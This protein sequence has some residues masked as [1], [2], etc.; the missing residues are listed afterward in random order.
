MTRG[1]G[2]T[3]R[4]ECYDD[5]YPAESG[6]QTLLE[7]E[8]RAGR[9][10]MSQERAD[11]VGLLL[12]AVAVVLGACVWF[13]IAGP[14][15]RAIADAAHLLVG[16]GA[17]VLPPALLVQPEPWQVWHRLRRAPCAAALWP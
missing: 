12:I 6:Q 10:P 11:S 15:G 16:A 1:I 5:E 7:G 3:M 17:L 2:G 9:A 8:S 13:N 4:P 14:V